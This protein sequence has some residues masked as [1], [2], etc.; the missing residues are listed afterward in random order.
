[1]YSP[2]KITL[3]QKVVYV[4]HIYNFQHHLLW[5]YYLVSTKL[6]DLKHEIGLRCNELWG[7]GDVICGREKLVLLVHDKLVIQLSYSLYAVI[8]L[9]KNTLLT[10]F[11]LC[12][13]FHRGF[14][15]EMQAVMCLCCG[16]SWPHVLPPFYFG[17]FRP[18]F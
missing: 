6:W 13:D 4:F 5:L 15:C 7:S 16:S 17:P 2:K 10:L 1:M 11:F 18:M 14:R 8:T 9:S 3:K 12:Y